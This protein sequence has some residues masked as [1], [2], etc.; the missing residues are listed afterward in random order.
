MT[1]KDGV[2]YMQKVENTCLARF[3]FKA[4]G[5]SHLNENLDMDNADGN[6]VHLTGENLSAIKLTNPKVAEG[7]VIPEP[8][9]LEYT[10][11]DDF[12]EQQEFVVSGYPDQILDETVTKVDVKDKMYA[13][14][15]TLTSKE[16][17]LVMCN[18]LASKGQ[19]GGGVVFDEQDK[20]FAIYTD[21][22]E[23]PN[24]GKN[25]SMCVRIT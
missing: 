18:L 21:Y 12:D 22:E 19:N 6:S 7:Q 15:G 10:D 17:K 20:L 24:S 25:L 2:F 13:S 9:P 11:N 1:L 4:E 23:D 3:H 8:S 14:K 16:D 5:V